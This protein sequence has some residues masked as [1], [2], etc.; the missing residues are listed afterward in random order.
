M[1]GREKITIEI[2]KRRKDQLEEALISY[3]GQAGV[4]LETSDRVEIRTAAGAVR[5]IKIKNK[6][7]YQVL[8]SKIGNV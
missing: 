4:Q 6:N 3:D 7:F 5:L 2:G 8:R 1:S